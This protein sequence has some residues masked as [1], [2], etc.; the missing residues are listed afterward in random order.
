MHGNLC[1]TDWLRGTD[2]SGCSKVKRP[3]AASPLSPSESRPAP[4]S[5]ASMPGSEPSTATTAAVIAACRA[6]AVRPEVDAAAAAAGAAARFE[7]CTSPAASPLLCDSCFCSA[8][9]GLPLCSLSQ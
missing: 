4:T 7:L 6:S 8:N 3:C 5:G 9:S 2:L 1:S